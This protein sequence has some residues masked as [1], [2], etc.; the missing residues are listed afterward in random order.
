MN[1][2]SIHRRVQQL[3]PAGIETCGLLNFGRLPGQLE[4]V[5]LDSAFRGRAR[6]RVVLRLAAETALAIQRAGLAFFA[7]S[8]VARAGLARQL[9]ACY[10][11]WRQ[12]AVS[13]AA[14]VTGMCAAGEA[15]VA[16][17]IG[18]CAIVQ[19]RR[20]WLAVLPVERLVVYGWWA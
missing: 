2:V 12:I 10:G 3:L 4:Q 15:A 7:Q 19:D 11:P 1:R 8:T 9:P 6:G 18:Y 14:P 17:R 20:G 16:H 5:L 13:A